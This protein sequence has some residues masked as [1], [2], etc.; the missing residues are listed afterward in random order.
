[1]PTGLEVAILDFHLSQTIQNSFWS[2]CHWITRPRKRRTT[3]EFSLPSCPSFPHAGWE[4]CIPRLAC[5][6]VD[7]KLLLTRQNSFI[8]LHISENK[9]LDVETVWLLCI[10]T[11]IC[12]SMVWRPP[13][14]VLKV[15]FGRTEISK[16]TLI[17]GF[18]STDVSVWISLL[19]N[20]E[21]K[22]HYLKFRGRQIGCSTSG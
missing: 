13:S 15:L 5:T 9:C 10:K 21:V 3:L 17:V 11:E 2:H 7:F 4:M 8:A 22:K 16:L 6:I 14:W 19:A 1:M 18:Q 20:L 12:V